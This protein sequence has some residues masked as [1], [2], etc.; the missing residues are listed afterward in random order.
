MTERITSSMVANQMLSTI[1]NDLNTLDTTENELA[2]GFQINEAGDNPFGAAQSLSLQS[3]IANYGSYESN[4]T[5]SLAWVEGQSG[6]LQNI[7]SEVQ[8]V[9]TSVVE[10]SNGT[11]SQDDLDDAAE[12]VLEAIGAI[13]SS[14]DTQDNNEY[15]FA[16]TA[17]TVPPYEQDASDTDQFNPDANTNPNNQLIGPSTTVNISANL[18]NV[19]GDGDGGTPPNSDGKLLSTL[20]QVYSDMESGNQQGLT[21][22]LSSLDTNMDSLLSLQAQVGATQDQLQD[23]DMQLQ[24][25]TTADSTQLGTTE[26]TNMGQAMLNYGTEQTSYE[27]ALQVSATIIQTSLLNYLQS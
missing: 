1:D 5:N 23:A 25:F 20:R 19:L 9:R 21:Q 3:Q 8:N 27:S 4:V 15:V 6:A 12:T 16:G 17:T 14:A 24:D 22:D 7:L 11:M 26:D 10:G 2:T 18:Y 13:K